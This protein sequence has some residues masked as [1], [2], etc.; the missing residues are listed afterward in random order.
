MPD[1]YLHQ[2]KKIVNNAS[3]PIYGLG[4]IGALIYFL[5]TA[6]GFW[7][8]AFGIIKAILWPAFLIYKLLEFLKA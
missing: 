8:G 7:N 4:F 2:T 6:T 3:N 5:Q 1:V